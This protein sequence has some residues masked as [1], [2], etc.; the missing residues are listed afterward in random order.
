MN[1]TKYSELSEEERNALFNQYKKDKKK[2][3]N[4][5]LIIYT[6]IFITFLA[7]ILLFYNN[8]KIDYKVEDM[9]KDYVRYLVVLG[10]VLMSIIY[11]ITLIVNIY[12]RSKLN[13][14]NTVAFNNYLFKKNIILDM[15]DNQNNKSI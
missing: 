3:L 6:I 10:I 1:Q 14:K 13:N 5:V 15:V 9:V 4:L 8:W 11:I 12:K 2:K 7:I